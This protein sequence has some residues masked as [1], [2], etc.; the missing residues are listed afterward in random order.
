M[1]RISYQSLLLPRI[2]DSSIQ[3]QFVFDTSAPRL[4]II[5]PFLTLKRAVI[6]LFKRGEQTNTINRPQNKTII[7]PGRTQELLESSNLKQLVSAGCDLDVMSPWSFTERGWNAPEQACS[8]FFFYRLMTCWP[9]SRACD[10]SL[11]QT[12]PSPK[13]PTSCISPSEVHEHK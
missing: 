2:S 11:K 1:I 12:K 5:Q 9:S 6:T 7:S 3:L 13:R 8:V 4:A 10:N